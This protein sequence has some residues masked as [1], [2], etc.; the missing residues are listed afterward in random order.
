MKAVLKGGNFIGGQPEALTQSRIGMAASASFSGD[1]GREHRRARLVSCEN[2]MLAMAIG[3][4]RGSPDTACN[5]F[6]VNALPKR[7]ENV[8]VTP[9]TGLWNLG[10]RNLRGRIARRQNRVRSMTVGANGSLFSCGNRP[11]VSAL[12]I[13][14]HRSDNQDAKFFDDLRVGMTDRARLRD[15][16]RVYGRIRLRT[17]HKLV[18]ITMATGARSRLFKTLCTCRG[19]DSLAVRFHR[20]GVAGVADSRFQLR[21]MRRRRDIYV[22]GRAFECAMDRLVKAGFVHVHGNA[23]A[24]A[25]FL[26]FGKT[27]A[28]EATVFAQRLRDKQWSGNDEK[29]NRQKPDGQKASGVTG[30]D[31][32]PNGMVARSMRG[33]S[34]SIGNAARG[35]PRARICF[36]PKLL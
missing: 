14:L 29:K 33:L 34:S 3:A 19:V 23:P 27:V 32:E 5:R 18:H 36:V 28:G 2:A 30:H 16:F 26:Q 17:A 12:Q 11:G 20:R 1:V 21:R 9:T 4:Y 31:T 6:A 8:G 25:G 7:G 24:F 22:T 10:R 35:D 15:I 13:G